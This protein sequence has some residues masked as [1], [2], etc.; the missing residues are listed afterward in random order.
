MMIVPHQ[1]TADVPL[2]L[3]TTLGVSIFWNIQNRTSS[4]LYL[5][6]VVAGTTPTAAEVAQ[7]YAVQTNEHYLA[8]GATPDVMRMPISRN[9]FDL[10]ALARVSGSLVAGDVY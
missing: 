9:G 3:T 10:W 5:M 4:W 8:P 1:I 2:N 7:G 6:E